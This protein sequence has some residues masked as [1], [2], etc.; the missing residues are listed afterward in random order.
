MATKKDK[1]G[2]WL[3]GGV[4]LV[5]VA[6]LGV[7]ATLDRAPKAQSDNCVGQPTAN[8]VILLDYSDLVPLQTRDEIVARAMAHVRNQVAVNERVSVF[9]I[10]ALSKKEL[11]PVVS[12]CRPP[13]DGNRMVED[14]SRIRR[15]FVERFEKPLRATLSVAPK[16]SPESPIAQ[17][18]TDISLSQYLRGQT[19]TLLIFSDMLENTPRFTLYRCATPEG[20][21]ASYRQAMRGAQERPHFQNTAV[22][23][24]LV[25]RLDQSPQT[26]A[27]RDKLWPWFFGDNEGTN[28]KLVV[29]YLPGG[30]PMGPATTKLGK[31]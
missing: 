21:V 30:T 22:S 17:A 14:V 12:L 16:E 25:P 1:Q 26:L 19:N 31:P 20:V 11:Q 15:L 24:N 18:V 4:A 8:T 23:L 27:C 9:T 29:D 13:E 7:K 2:Y 10:S 3:I 6:V 28:A 5:L